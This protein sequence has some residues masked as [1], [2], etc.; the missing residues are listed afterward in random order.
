MAMKEDEERLDMDVKVRCKR[1]G[2]TE[3]QWR[4]CRQSGTEVCI[5]GS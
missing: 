1:D 4:L 5:H 3:T 2:E